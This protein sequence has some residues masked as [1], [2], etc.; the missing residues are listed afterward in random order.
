MQDEPTFIPN[1]AGG[2]S[3]RPGLQASQAMVTGEPLVPVPGRFGAVDVHYPATGGARAALVV[4]A[5]L[6]RATTVEEHVTRLDH[7]LP[8]RPGHFY[9]R[10][11][12]AL[13]QVLALTGRLDLIVVDG[14]VDLDPHGRSGL[15]A[16]VHREFGVPVIGVAKTA[17]RAATQAIPVLRGDATRPLYI[18]AAGMDSTLAA[19]WVAQL[20]GPYRLPDVLRRADALSRGST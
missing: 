6:R 12:P 5:D 15:G 14:Y 17:Y 20:A 16:H 8:Y 11:L 4:S 3:P 19:S 13:R 9:A 18:T 10:E 2:R 1:G 7:V